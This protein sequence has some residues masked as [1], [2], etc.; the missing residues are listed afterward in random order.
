MSKGPPAL[1]RLAARSASF[2]DGLIR[3]GDNPMGWKGWMSVKGTTMRRYIASFLV[4]GFSLTVGN[5]LY[6]QTAEI[7]R[8][9]DTRIELKK[10]EQG[11]VLRLLTGQSMTVLAPILLEGYWNDIQATGKFFH[12]FISQPTWMTDRK[13]KAPK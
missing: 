11:Q 8:K 3:L 2:L 1:Q 5:R 9:V 7:Q 13:P 12:Q 6:A 10:L 4:L